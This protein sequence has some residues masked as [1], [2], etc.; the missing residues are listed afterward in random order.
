MFIQQLIEISKEHI[1]QT[2][3]VIA[4][5]TDMKVKLT[6]SDKKY[7]DLIIQDASKR[8]D[9]KCWE[10]EEKETF[11]KELNANQAVKIKGVV[12]EY[13]GI[14][15]LTIKDIEGVKESEID[16]R[17]LIPTSDWEIESMKKGLQYFYDKVKTPHLKEL[18]DKMI[19]TTHHYE[20]FC[21][22]PAAR[23]VHHN[24]YHGLLQHVLEVLKYAYTVATTKKLSQRQ[25]ERLIVMSFL[26][27]WAKIMEYKQLPETGFTEE[28]TMLGHI[29]MGAHMTLNYINEIE[30]F[31]S[32]DKL[33][34]LNGILGHHGKL[35]YGSPVLPKTV[36]A[37]ILHHAD[38][39]SGDIESIQSF[40]K[41]E[42]GKEDT[43]TNKLWN[44]GTEYYK[45]G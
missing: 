33:I 11:F 38:I 40:M 44:M 37:Q 27:D 42:E 32:E 26:H 28:G 20:K 14:L 43:F 6:K 34:V 25:L 3:E 36:E 35:E 10:Y 8:I 9:A 4:M 16:I 21:S 13:Q 24:F 19:F 1:N 2:I 39:M 45:K 22:Y 41:E 12:G 17:A 18:L 31:D 5:V 23:Q 7:I 30:N 29:F 15:Q